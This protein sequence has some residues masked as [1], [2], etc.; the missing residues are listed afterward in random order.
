MIG[1]PPAARACFAHLGLDEQTWVRYS[2]DAGSLVFADIGWEES[3][4]H[5]KTMLTRLDHCHAF[6]P[7][8]AEAMLLT[9][10][11]TPQR[12]LS[13]LSEYVPVVAITCGVVGAIA[14]D[15]RTGECA[16]VPA[17]AVPAIDPTGA[18]DVFGAGFVVGTL[19]G[20]P[21][22]YRLRF[23]AV[24]A[25]LSVQ[26]FGGSLGAPGWGEIV[27]WWQAERSRQSAVSAEYA[28]LDDLLPG[29]ALSPVRRAAA[30]LQYRY[31]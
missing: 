28:F 10:T 21:L 1:S 14:L 16:Q 8:A 6:L 30:T 2:H 3:E 7:N 12:A 4:A 11:D 15:Q 18:G 29:A 17:L 13:A 25:A 26:H 31:A 9:G 27:G 22:E 20:W 24:C 19:A 23:A 5:A